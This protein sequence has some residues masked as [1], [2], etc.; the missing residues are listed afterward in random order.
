MKPGRK[1]PASIFGPRLVSCHDPAA[2][3]PTAAIVFLRIEPVGPREGHRFGNREVGH[4][5]EDLVHQLRQLSTSAGAAVGNGFP[6]L[7][8]ERAN[9]VKRFFIPANH[10]R[11][12]CI[13]RA[14]VAAADGGVEQPHA[15]GSQL[16]RHLARRGGEMVE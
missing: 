10:D 13:S 15:F 1:S 4:A 6:K 7:F 14:D 5:H 8:K 16:L 2:P 9:P 11:Q 12:R 3:P